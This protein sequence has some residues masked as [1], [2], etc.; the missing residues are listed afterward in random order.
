MFKIH[1][2]WLIANHKSREHGEEFKR[3]ERC[4]RCDK[5][6]TGTKFWVTGDGKEEGSLKSLLTFNLNKHELQ[7]RMIVWGISWVDTMIHSDYYVLLETYQAL[8]QAKLVYAFELL[9]KLSCPPRKIL[10]HPH[11]HHPRK[12]ILHHPF[13]ISLFIVILQLNLVFIFSRIIIK[14]TITGLYAK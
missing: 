11:I 14:E 3:L 2:I 12:G 10:L 1:A 5:H 6:Y 9:H 7:G 13:Y 4:G 8:K